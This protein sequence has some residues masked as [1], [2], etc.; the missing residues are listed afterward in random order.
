[1]EELNGESVFWLIAMGM[2]IGGVAKLTMG[3]KGVGLVTNVAVGA[4]A[5]LLVGCVGLAIQ[6]PGSFLFAF[7]GG[8]SV[9]FLSNV[10][11]VQSDTHYDESGTG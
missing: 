4:V 9:L 7:L 8:I 11:F 3:K 6:M 5:T 1:M 2:F 10:F